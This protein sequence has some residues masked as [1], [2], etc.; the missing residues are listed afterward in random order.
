M[1]RRSGTTLA[2]LLLM[3]VACTSDSP[4]DVLSSSPAT[5]SPSPSAIVVPD[6]VGRNFLEA[7]VA[8]DPPFRLLDV[9]YQVSS[10]VP[11]GTI[12]TQRPPGGTAFDPTGSEIQIRVVVA[13]S[14][15]EL[16]FP[17]TLLT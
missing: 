5:S 13:R 1:M 6:V 17:R 8:L 4:R 11:N 16:S 2:I 9:R 14:P 12:L 3:L 7:S 10:E 15:S